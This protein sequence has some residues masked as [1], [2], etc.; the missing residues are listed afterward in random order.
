MASSTAC[1]E[2]AHQVHQGRL[3]MIATGGILTGLD[4]FEKLARG[5][6]A[7]QIY[8]GW[9]YEGPGAVKRINAGLLRLLERDGFKR[10]TEAIGVDVRK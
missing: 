4:V 9:I 3:P 2:W 5:A 7:V 10:I 1:L 6:T 8:T